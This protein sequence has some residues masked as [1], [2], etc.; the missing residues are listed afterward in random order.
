[1]AQARHKAPSHW[2]ARPLS[3]PKQAPIRSSG[4]T[5]A[6][7]GGDVTWTIDLAMPATYRV[8]HRT[9]KRNAKTSTALIAFAAALYMA[10]AL[11]LLTHWH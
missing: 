2:G 6:H 8:S 11:Y 4:A 7:A 3:S 1:M 10:D 9:A 5:Q